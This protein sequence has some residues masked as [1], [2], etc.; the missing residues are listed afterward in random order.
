MVPW[1]EAGG[2]TV[3]LEDRSV[4]VRRLLKWKSFQHVLTNVAT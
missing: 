3:V 1:A 4:H 2:T